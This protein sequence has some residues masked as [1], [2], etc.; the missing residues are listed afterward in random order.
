MLGLLDGARGALGVSLGRL[1]SAA[2]AMLSPRPPEILR[3]GH[4]REMAGGSLGEAG[5]GRKVG[6]LVRGV[7]L[8]LRGCKR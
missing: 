5:E 3:V 8:L 1:V 6:I 2:A 7:G 4:S